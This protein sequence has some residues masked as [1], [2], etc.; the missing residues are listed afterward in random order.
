M[1]AVS[2]FFVRDLIYLVRARNN[3][4]RRQKTKTHVSLCLSAC[5]LY[6]VW[7]FAVYN[8]A[9]PPYIGITRKISPRNDKKNKGQQWDFFWKTHW[10]I[11]TIWRNAI[12]RRQTDWMPWCSTL[13][14]DSST[15]SPRNYRKTEDNSVMNESQL[16]RQFTIKWAALREHLLLKDHVVK[17]LCSHTLPEK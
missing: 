13:R 10:N 17:R 16:R 9:A 15:T 6:T 3:R 5:V 11:C 14:C 12:I 4:T 2:H 1:T 8:V 7:Y